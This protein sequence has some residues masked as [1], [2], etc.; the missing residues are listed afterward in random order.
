MALIECPECGESVSNKAESCPHCGFPFVE[1]ET[2]SRAR[3][4]PAWLAVDRC[5]F[6]GCRV[7][8]DD[9]IM[10]DKKNETCQYCAFRIVRDD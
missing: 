4:N 9:R 7:V 3:K 5:R 10:P 1:K 6:C 8:T 2:P